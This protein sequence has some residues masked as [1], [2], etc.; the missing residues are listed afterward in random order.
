MFGQIIEKLDS[1]NSSLQVLIQQNKIKETHTRVYHD[2]LMTRTYFPCSLNKALSLLNFDNES[3]V[4]VFINGKSFCRGIKFGWV[5]YR[6]SNILIDDTYDFTC[7]LDIRISIC[8]NEID[9]ICKEV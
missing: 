4:D 9:I 3:I 7:V 6:A 5:K 2:K 1:I 8:Y